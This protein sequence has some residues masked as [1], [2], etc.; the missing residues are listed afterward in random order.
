MLK[1]E[2]VSFKNE[3]KSDLVDTLGAK[4]ES[5]EQKIKDSVLKVVHDELVSVKDEFNR[6][7]D[8]LSNKLEQKLTK[9][10]ENKI[11]SQVN[12]KLK[13][14]AN[15]LKS[16]LGI[17]EMKSDISDMKK[18]YADT[19]K[20]KGGVNCDLVIRSCAVDPKEADDPNVTLHK[21]NAIIRDGIKLND[22]KITKAV[23]KVSR[24]NKPGVIIATV[25]SAE[26][27][28]TILANKKKLRPIERF[29]NI[30]IE[31]SPA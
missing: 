29:R 9:T 27:K 5:F 4:F 10:L 24:N 31:E 7:I 12:E 20:S 19:V 30:Y 22:I 3:I 1:A 18:T 17:Q 16:D 21:V 2:F 8:G 26:Q 13:Q 28:D 6:R 15:K 11:E 25:E 14:S 23:R